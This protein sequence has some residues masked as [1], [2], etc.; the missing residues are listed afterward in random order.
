MI[1]PIEAS[2]EKT[3]ILGLGSRPSIGIVLGFYGYWHEVIGL[4]QVL[5]HS[6]RAYILNPDANYLRGFLNKHDK[7]ITEILYDSDKQGKL[8]YIKKY[9]E[10]DLDA[11]VNGLD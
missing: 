2:L 8:E 3:L 1:V 10:L 4:M 5:S 6:T 9:L 11:I 7:S